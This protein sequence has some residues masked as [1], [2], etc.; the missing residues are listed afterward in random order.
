MDRTGKTIV[1][2]PYTQ[3]NWSSLGFLSQNLHKIQQFY[4]AK[5]VGQG[6]IHSAHTWRFFIDILLQCFAYINDGTITTI[7]YADDIITLCKTLD[8]LQLHADIVSVF[9]NLTGLQLSTDKLRSFHKS[10]TLHQTAPRAISISSSNWTNKNIPLT[11]NG[12]LRYLG[13]S[14]DITPFRS[15]HTSTQTDLAK[16]TLSKTVATLLLKNKRFNSNMLYRIFQIK[17]IPQLC[18]GIS[19]T[20][21]HTSYMSSLD[22]L[23]RKLIKTLTKNLVQFP[24][25]LIHS[26]LSLG[27]LNTPSLQMHIIKR[28]N[29][30]LHTSLFHSSPSRPTALSMIQNLLTQQ[31]VSTAPGSTQ[32][33]TTTITTS[34]FNYL[35]LSMKSLNI[36][37]SKQGYT[38]SDGNFPVSLLRL[39][40]GSI[41]KIKLYGYNHVTDFIQSIHGILSYKLPN[42]L[43]FL[44]HHLVP[45]ENTFN[46]FVLQP[47]QFWL[48]DNSIAHINSITTTTITL[49]LLNAYVALRSIYTFTNIPLTTINLSQFLT[50]TKLIMSLVPNTVSTYVLLD[51]VTTNQPFLSSQPILPWVAHI[52]AI[53]KNLPYS[54]Y[55][56]YTDGSHTITSS[57]PDTLFLGSTT[58]RCGASIIITSAQPNWMTQ[59]I[60][61]IHI[62]NTLTES[63]TSAYPLELLA[64]AAAISLVSNSNIYTDCKS[65]V[66]LFNSCKLNDYVNKD[67]FSIIQYIH[68]Q[69]LLSHNTLHWTRSHPELRHRNPSSWTRHDKGNYLADKYASKPSYS[70]PIYTLLPSKHITTSEIMIQFS[71][72]NWTWSM[73]SVPILYA[74]LHYFM[75]HHHSSYISNRDSNAISSSSIPWKTRHTSYGS[76]LLNT[77]KSDIITTARSCRLLYDLYQHGRNRAK[78]SPHLSLCSGCH[79]PDSLK[80]ILLHCTHQ[81]QTCT[82]HSLQT[83]VIKMASTLSGSVRTLFHRINSLIQSHPQGYLILAGTWTPAL[84]KALSQSISTS[85]LQLPPA[86]V[87]FKKLS[88]IFKLQLN[89]SLLL[90]HNSHVTHLL[91]QQKIPVSRPTSSPSPTISQT[92]STLISHYLPSSSPSLSARPNMSQISSDHN[93][94]IEAEYAKISKQFTTRKP[95]RKKIIRASAASRHKTCTPDTSQTKLTDTFKIL[96]SS[97]VRGRIT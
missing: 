52:R 85:N 11:H 14:H 50:T 60:L 66:A 86:R 18:Y 8:S 53:I 43:S 89:T 40:S 4:A 80:H 27:G 10:D 71:T 39:T 34:Y 15:T 81:Q 76:A 51:S 73:N 1:R 78:H 26:P 23:H 96:T 47:N 16:S 44:Q 31:H 46:H 54:S 79:Q 19:L 49:Q 61:P 84:T 94:R 3:K 82:R 91:S 72:L 22:V 7:A 42:K 45:I 38:Q 59:P 92:Q 12:T 41:N 9:C 58:S 65:A 30:I 20:H 83:D 55:N 90:L 77:S 13:S 56:I 48:Y 25:N 68:D 95:K 21:N 64:I 28:Q 57:M 97:K 70:D 24:T 5:G 62:T 35:V 93:C 37:L 75:H 32:H 33:T 36:S 88:P 2:T 74:P 29:Q 63:L 87:L 17:T 6:D 69:L 67:Y